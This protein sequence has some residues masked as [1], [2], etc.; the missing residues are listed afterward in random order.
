MQNEEYWKVLIEILINIGRQSDK[1]KL[2]LCRNSIGPKAPEQLFP[3]SVWTYHQQWGVFWK[4]SVDLVL[5]LIYRSKIDNVRYQ[6]KQGLKIIIEE[7]TQEGNL[8]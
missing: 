6:L 8:A 1:D 2:E 7:Y 3:F 4:V 5:N